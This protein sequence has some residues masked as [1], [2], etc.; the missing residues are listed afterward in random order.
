MVH[1]RDLN[2]IS[3]GER[4]ARSL[5]VDTARTTLVLLLAASFLAAVSVAVSGIIGFVGLLVPHMVRLF[6]GPDNRVL[7]PVSMAAGA[8]LLT[9]AD[10]VS[11]A[12]LP[13]EIPIGVL[14]ALIGGPVFCWIFRRN[15]IR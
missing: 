14:T 4:S 13:H 2:L 7:I 5:G 6:F 11:R 9:L 15:R 10:T 1:A 8:C 3:L 12:V